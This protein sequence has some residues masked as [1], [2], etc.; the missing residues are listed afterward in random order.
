MA[1]HW[2]AVLL[3]GM[4][5]TAERWSEERGKGISSEGESDSEGLNE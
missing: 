1:Q 5:E 4:N 3:S 2:V